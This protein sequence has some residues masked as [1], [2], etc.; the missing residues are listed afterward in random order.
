MPIERSAQGQEVFGANEPL[1]QDLTKRR[2][3]YRP[4][5]DIYGGTAG[6]YTYGPPGCALKNNI[7]SLWRKHFIIEESMM[8]IE[9]PAV[10]PYRVLDA[11][12]HVERFSDFMVKDLKDDGKFCECHTSSLLIACEGCEE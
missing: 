11:S 9:D 5:F 3:F 10:T 2:F 8:E 6:L 1:L 12:G 4:A 7:Q